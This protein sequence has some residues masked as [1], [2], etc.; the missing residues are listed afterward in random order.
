MFGFKKNKNSDDD[1]TRH[2]QRPAGLPMD[3]YASYEIDDV[4]FHDKN[5]KWYKA[6][7]VDS[8]L[9]KIKQTLEWHEAREATMKDTGTEPEVRT[10]YSWARKAAMEDTPSE[11][12][13][14]PLDDDPSLT[15][16]VPLADAVDRINEEVSSGSPNDTVESNYD[17]LPSS[18]YYPEVNGVINQEETTSQT[19][20]SDTT[21]IVSDYE[22]T[23]IPYTKEDSTS[24]TVPESQYQQSVREQAPIDDDGIA[25]NH[26]QEDSEP[27]ISDQQP[28]ESQLD[29]TTTVTAPVSSP[30]DAPKAITNP[31]LRR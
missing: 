4:K 8:L 30:C 7:E 5:A 15:I 3:L 31:F 1:T 19:V 13:P 10:S 18:E 27:F 16:P 6:T 11:D 24:Q 20:P 2:P 26:G 14:E 23:F 9:D 25:V 28:V 12:K 17:F 29:G 21:G 22:D